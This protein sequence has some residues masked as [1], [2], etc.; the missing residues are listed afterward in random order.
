VMAR[1]GRLPLA[2][3]DLS[4]GLTF[5]L[6]GAAKAVAGGGALERRRLRALVRALR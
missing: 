6:R 4:E 2:L 1:E 3:D 5:A